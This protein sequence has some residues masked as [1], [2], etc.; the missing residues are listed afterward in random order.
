M[1]CDGATQEFS[2]PGSSVSPNARSWTLGGWVG[3]GSMCLDKIRSAGK[4]QGFEFLELGWG[5][6]GL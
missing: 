6:G 4:Q 2:S 1:A 5:V 3:P